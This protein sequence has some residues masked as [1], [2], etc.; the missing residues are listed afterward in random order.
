MS[1]KKLLINEVFN[2]AKKE[3]DR[4]TKNGLASYL[5]V[6]FEE[7]LSITI[8]ERSFVRYYE[9]YVVGNA[10]RN[11]EPDRLNKMSQYLGYKD[12]VDFSRTFIK[13]DDDANKTTVKISVDDDENSFSEK[14]SNIII[15]ITN[16]SNFTVPEFV[17]Q[18]GFGIAGLILIIGALIANSELFNAKAKNNMIT[19]PSL[20][21]GFTEEKKCMYWDKSEYKLADC[22]SKH[23]YHNLKPLDTVLF[24]QFK[25]ITRK[26]TLTVQN[27]YGKTW[28]SKYNGEVAFFTMDGKDPDNGRELR[29]STPYIIYK[30]GGKQQDSIGVEE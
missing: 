7:H 8:S 20:L 19:T 22:E 3:S 17:K 10:E 4:D 14:L 18:N 26:D 29:S 28:Y 5:W 12:F 1:K 23:P 13:K 27:A 2:Q 21:F 24:N 11:I 25:R 30:Y 15:H 6:Y 9:D 16:Q